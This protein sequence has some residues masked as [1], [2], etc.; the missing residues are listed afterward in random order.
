MA[1]FQIKD[2][3]LKTLPSATLAIN[4]QSAAMIASGRKVIRFGFGQSPF[5]VPDI[6]RESLRAHAHE[7]AYLPV[8]GLQGLR[9]AAA[10]FLSRTRDID[11]TA[12][13]ILIGPGSKELIY[14][15]QTCLKGTLY[16]PTPSWVSYGPQSEIIGNKVKWLHTRY[17]ASWKVT[18]EM[19]ESEVNEQGFLILNYPNNP[20]GMTYTAEELMAI[21]EVARRKELL[22]ISDEIYAMTSFSGSHVSIAKFYPEG[23]IISTGLSKWCGAGGWRLGIASFPEA[24]ADFLKY[25]AILASETFT[26]VNAP[27]QF[28]AIT[29]YEEMDELALYL[30]QTR[31]ILKVVSEL[32]YQKLHEIKIECARPQGGYYFFVDFRNYREQLNARGITTSDELC[33]KLL[34]DKAVAMLPGS[35]FGRSPEELNARLSFVDFDGIKALENVG[36]LNEDDPEN[37]INSWAPNV[38]IGISRIESW[39]TSQQSL[40]KKAE[41]KQSINR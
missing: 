36:T 20:T 5:P 6:V 38:G 40:S 35:V 19:L 34:N 39:L 30:K 41:L 27:V 26:S 13:Q 32:A 10:D 2:H 9:V 11:L 29:A 37:W 3:I 17:K 25:V 21:A 4:E 24:C 31:Q 14:L 22:V 7:K 15:M 33:K 18:A 8:K 12:E 28:A 23:T 1:V 16:L